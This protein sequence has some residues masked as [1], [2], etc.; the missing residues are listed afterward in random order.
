MGKEK[1]LV[2]EKVCKIKPEAYLIEWF[3]NTQRDMFVSS[4][5]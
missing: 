2:R 1:K 5:S 3:Q 4:G